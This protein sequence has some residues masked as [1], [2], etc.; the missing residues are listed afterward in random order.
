VLVLAGWFQVSGAWTGDFDKN[1]VL[2]ESSL[3]S[4]PTKEEVGV[5]WWVYGDFDEDLVLEESSLYLI[6]TKEEVGVGWLV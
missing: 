6:P 5:G 2:E 3:Y 4:I 1:L